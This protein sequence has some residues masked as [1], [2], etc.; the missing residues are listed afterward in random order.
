MFKVKERLQRLVD[1]LVT[2]ALARTNV[3]GQIEQLKKQQEEVFPTWIHKLQNDLDQGVQP[4]L[5][6][7]KKFQNESVLPWLNNLERYHHESVVPWLNNIESRFKDSILPWLNNLE[8]YHHESVVP[9]LT[10]IQHSLDET[11]SQ[12]SV[13][14]GAKSQLDSMNGSIDELKEELL[15]KKIQAEKTVFSDLSYRTFEDQMRGDPS[16]IRKRLAFYDPVIHRVI[17]ENEGGPVFA[18]DLGCGRGEFIELLAKEY[19]VDVMGI[20]SNPD[21]V[22]A[23]NEKQLMT[24]QCDI[25]DYLKNQETA[26]V[27]LVSMIHVAEHFPVRVLFEVIREIRRVL[28]PGGACILETPNPENLIVGA[29]NFYAD[30]S[31]IR[32]LPPA[33]LHLLTKC[34]G[35]DESEILRMHWYGAVA[36]EYLDGQDGIQAPIK[37][38]AHF[39]N[40]CADYSVI[41]YLAKSNGKSASK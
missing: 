14:H 34:A 27:D 2:G 9:W 38:I 36:T 39:L 5:D 41:G 17:K 26:S 6:G 15:I 40:N 8:R 10:N 33:L 7:V 35:F 25:L 20:D 23:C 11:R 32:V 1:R 21:M 19:K 29:C 18:L 3:T 12:V 31:H 13:L 28:R 22:A 37:Q 4:Q 30:P 24:V 16:V